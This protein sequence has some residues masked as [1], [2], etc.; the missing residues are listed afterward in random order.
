MVCGGAQKRVGWL[1][2][3]AVMVVPAARYDS[4]FA[5]INRVL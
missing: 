3:G 2:D 5:L 4:A 1:K